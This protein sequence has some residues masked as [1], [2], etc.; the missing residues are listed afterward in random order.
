MKTIIWL[1]LLIT[2]F[3]LALP[4]YRATYSAPIKPELPPIREYAEKMVYQEFGGQWLEFEQIIN[5]E[6]RWD[7]E[8]QNPKS[9]AY[10]IGQFLNSTWKTVGCVKTSNP[11]VQID[12]MIKYVKQRYETP[13]KAL[14]FHLANNHY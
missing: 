9:T 10:G 4:P 14:K 12:C 6:S 8:A 1:V 2:I 3:F 5:R 7:N 13:Y 11:Y